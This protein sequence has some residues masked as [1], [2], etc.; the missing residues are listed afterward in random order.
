MAFM[1]I[2]SITTVL[3]FQGHVNEITA[4]KLLR[5]VSLSKMPLGIIQVAVRGNSFFQCMDVPQFIYPFRDQKTF[6]LFVFWGLKKKFYK[7][8]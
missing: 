1:D 6:A 8:V 2:F 5:P 4:F 3:S 7:L